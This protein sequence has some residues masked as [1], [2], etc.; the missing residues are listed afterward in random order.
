MTGARVVELSATPCEAAQLLTFPHLSAVDGFVHAVTTKPWNLAPH[1]GPEADRA[2][3]RRRALCARLGLPFDRLTA[4]DQIHSG[5]V[6]RVQPSDAGAGRFGRDDAVRFVDGLVT[7]LPGL[8]L[9]QL[10]AD[11]PLVVVVDGARRAFGTAHASWR[12]TV[13]GITRTLVRRMRAEFGSDPGALAAAICPCAGPDRY[14]I[15][16][17]VQRIA[18]TMLPEVDGVFPMNDRGRTCFDLRRAN[19]AQL[20]AEGV[21][22]EQIAIAE[23]CTMSDPRFYSHRRE[24]AATGR[25]GL[26][27]AF[28]G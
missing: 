11:C 16:G 3:E 10:S 14:E 2:V 27:A 1:R 24:G 15:G 28:R 7:D 23:P 21:R 26:I 19:V 20:V 13:A 25:F 9:L 17:D 18:R 6:L 22:A 12:G 5:H 8:P 4:P